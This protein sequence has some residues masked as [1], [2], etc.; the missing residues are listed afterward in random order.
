M[1]IFDQLPASGPISLRARLFAIAGSFFLVACMG[2]LIRKRLLKPS[3]SLLWLLMSAAIVVLAV[4][5]EVLFFISQL[6]GIYYVPATLFLL[7]LVIIFLVALHYSLV[8]TRLE[9]KLAQLTQE[10][11][12]QSLKKRKYISKIRT[13]NKP[14]S[15]AVSKKLP[16]KTIDT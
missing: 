13:T 16:R 2:L 7:A 15:S 10:V 9:K 14:K 3:Y 6:L 12:L 11:A 8:I 5:S 1:D 4:F